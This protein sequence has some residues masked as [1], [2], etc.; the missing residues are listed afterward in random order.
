[1]EVWCWYINKFLPVAALHPFTFCVEYRAFQNASEAHPLGQPNKKCIMASTEA[2]GVT[3]ME[4]AHKF[5]NKVYRIEQLPKNINKKLAY[6]DFEKWWKNTKDNPSGMDLV[7]TEFECYIDTSKFCNKYII[8]DGRQLKHSSWTNDGIDMF[9]KC[10]SLAMNARNATNNRVPMEEHAMEWICQL[11]SIT[12]TT[13]EEYQAAQQ[14]KKP[15][16]V[17]KSSTCP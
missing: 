14:K 11:H 10:V 5:W 7:N 1:V 4:G 12:A 15:K 13:W 6:I 2:F 17:P 8:K 9:K 16:V 3:L